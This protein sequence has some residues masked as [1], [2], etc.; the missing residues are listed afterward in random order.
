MINP[1]LENH[2][3]RLNDRFFDSYRTFPKHNRNL[4]TFFKRMVR[5]T[6]CFFPNFHARTSVN[7]YTFGTW[8]QEFAQPTRA[9]INPRK[10]HQHRLIMCTHFPTV[11][12]TL[13]H[14][15]SRSRRH[16]YIYFSTMKS[17]WTRPCSCKT[18]SA[19]IFRDFTTTPVFAAHF[20]CLQYL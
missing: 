19:E 12:F 1:S 6:K 17:N 4:V 18:V 11:N 16:G 9:T 8:F 13:Y 2:N 3:C 15:K 20:D 7:S 10:C 5:F 14:K